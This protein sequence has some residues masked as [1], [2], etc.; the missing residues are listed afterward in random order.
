MDENKGEKS[1]T[2]RYET[3]IDHEYNTVLMAL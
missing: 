1:A 2:T 3:A